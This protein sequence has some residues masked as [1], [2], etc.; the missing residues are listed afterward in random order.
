MGKV[1][2]DKQGQGGS[3]RHLRRAVLEHLSE[4]AGSRKPTQAAASFAA[5]SPSDPLHVCS[6]ALLQQGAS[7]P[8][9]PQCPCRAPLA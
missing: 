7:C 6:L 8:G 1:Q 2:G 4:A 5:L 3:C 9:M